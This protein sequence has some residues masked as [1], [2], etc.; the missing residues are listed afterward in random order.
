VNRGG[1]ANE[2]RFLANSLPS[3]V[4]CHL[5]RFKVKDL[6][7]DDSDLAK[8]VEDDFVRKEARLK[9]FYDQ[10]ASAQHGG[11]G[12]SRYM[13]GAEEEQAHVPFPTV[14]TALSVSF[15]VLALYGVFY[16]I[17]VSSGFRVY[18]VSVVLK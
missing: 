5:K 18:M 13:L 12:S 9:L 11:N 1:R 14:Y 8:W 15:W 17:W 2:K 10:L 7:K 3:E 6:P 16:S 4:H